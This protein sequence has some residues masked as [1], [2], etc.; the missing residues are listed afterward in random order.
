[1][2]DEEEYTRKN[3]EVLLNQ[4]LTLKKQRDIRENMTKNAD[5]FMI[6]S[7]KNE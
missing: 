5:K 3:N 4:L 7:D 1:M 6:I 2:L